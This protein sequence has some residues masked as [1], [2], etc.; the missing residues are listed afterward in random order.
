MRTGT[1]LAQ[2]REGHVNGRPAGDV[3][4]VLRR[5]SFSLAESFNPRNYL[6]PHG[7]HAM[8]SFRC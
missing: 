5:E 4:E 8:P 3:E 2:F 6:I 7:F 1:L